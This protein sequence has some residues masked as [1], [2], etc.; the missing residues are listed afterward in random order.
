MYTNNLNWKKYG[1]LFLTLSWKIRF[2]TPVIGALEF[3]RSFNSLKL[4]YYIIF[5]IYKN[6]APL[7]Y[8]SIIV[9]KLKFSSSRTSRKLYI[10]KQIHYK[11]FYLDTSWRGYG[12]I[13]KDPITVR[14]LCFLNITFGSIR[15]IFTPS[16]Y[17]ISI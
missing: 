3:E 7:V 2:L 11:S 4:D 17:N 5:S 16:S 6:L 13:R 15:N 1:A 12:T 10:N 14:N 9:I 8:R